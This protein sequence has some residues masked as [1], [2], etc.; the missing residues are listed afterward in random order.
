[1]EF[2]VGCFSLL[3]SPSKKS[4]EIE[5][6]LFHQFSACHISRDFQVFSDIYG[7]SQV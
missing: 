3:L 6:F 2:R 1:M 7:A 4:E 5:G